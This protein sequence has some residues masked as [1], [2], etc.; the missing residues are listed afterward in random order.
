MNMAHSRPCDAKDSI[1]YQTGILEDVSRTFAL[2]I[3]QLP[4]QL[5]HAVGNAYL[6]CRIADTIE[7]S[8]ALTARQKTAFADRLIAVINGR[9]DPDAF[10][11]DLSELLSDS[12]SSSELDL[13][14]NTAHVINITSQLTDVQRR[15]IERCVRIMTDGMMEF[16]QNAGVGGL[17][18]IKD[19]DRYCYCVAGVVGE[20]LTEMFCDYSAEIGSQRDELLSLAVSFGQGLQMTNILKDMWE[21]RLRGACWLPREVFSETGVELESVVAGREDPRMAKGV[22][23][24]VAIAMQHLDGALRYI[25]IIPAKETGIRRHC[26]WAL[27]FAVLTL[28]RIHSTP[29]YSK[30]DDVKISRRSV[31]AVIAATNLLTRSDTAL[32]LLFAAMTIG[33]PRAGSR[34]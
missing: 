4:G 23:E 1:A 17:E 20:M 6:L 16:Q 10:A 9:E 26:L 3:P 5:R 21:D 15:A 25:L 18:S 14:T 31:K 7:D 32:R 22:R 12:T 27:G 34:A 24:L 29:A 19:M 33:L 28:R 30:G 13:V 11:A 2:T 8:T